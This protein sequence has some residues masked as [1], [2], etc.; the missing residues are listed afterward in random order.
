[1]EK[2]TSI[3]M[4]TF[5]QSLINLR[6]KNLITEETAIA[7]SDK[8]SDMKVKLKSI[9]YAGDAKHGAKTLRNLD[10]SVLSIKD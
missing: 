3:G 6:R 9:R 8:P 4:C 7:N 1:M 5:D 2:N 10:T